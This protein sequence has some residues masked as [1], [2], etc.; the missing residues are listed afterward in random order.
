MEK[1]K[2][3]LVT[4]A[5]RG[6]GRA[7][8][9]G[10]ADKGC[11]V[12]VTS[13]SPAG[14]AVAE[15]INGRGGQAH[16]YQ[17]D[18]ANPESIA[19]VMEAIARDHGRLDILI[20]NAGIHYDTFQNTMTADFA[21]VEEAWRVNTLGPWRMTKAAYPLLRRS[22][23]RARGSRPFV[24]DAGAR[25]VNVSSSSGSFE[26]SWPGTPAYSVSKAALNMLT[27]KMA[28]DL[29]EDGI[30]V[31]AVCPGWV[32]TDMGGA[33]APRSPEEGAASVLWAAFIPDN[34]PTGG[35]FRDG[36]PVSW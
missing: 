29:K 28:A 3:A 36:E 8:A 25:V 20:N 15:E 1:Q 10:L 17:L 7:A 18:V 31:N 9:L 22:P 11:R 16:F 4:G 19:T 2:I 30:L 24:A 5:N 6:I 33:A 12:L 27:L 34:G 23:G 32:R 26:D 14:K 13:R 21:I 35:F